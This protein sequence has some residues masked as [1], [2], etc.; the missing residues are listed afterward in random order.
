MFF[1]CTKDLD[2]NTFMTIITPDDSILVLEDLDALFVK[3]L[4]IIYHFYS[5]K[6]SRWYY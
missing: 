1:K 4:N 2:D 6:C 3:I 5:I